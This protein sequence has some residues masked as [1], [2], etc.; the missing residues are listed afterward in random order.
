MSTI[1]VLSL[2]GSLIVPA[3]SIDVNFLK[4][5]R[6]CL[7]KHLKNNNKKFYLITGGGRTARDY[8]K[9]AQSVVRLNKE[10]L[11]WIGIKATCINAQLIKAI[12]LKYAHPQIFHDPYKIKKVPEKICVASG[13][14]PGWSTDYDAVVIAKKLGV[15][16]VINLSNIDYI[17]TKDPRKFKEAKPIKEITWKDFKKIV[18][19]KWTPGANLPF[20]PMACKL[21]EQEKIS[22]VVIN[23]YKL[24]NLNKFLRGD[25]FVGSVIK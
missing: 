7:I 20:D 5:F 4:N 8:I 10:E 9:A 1:H 17:Y 19:N 25:K 24:Q 23:G 18:G 6:R 2:G 15:K 13:W 16:T 3:N 11:D 21:A 12:F 14:L 22:V